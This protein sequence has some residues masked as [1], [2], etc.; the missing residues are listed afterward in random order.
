MMVMVLS[1]IFVVAELGLL[2]CTILTLVCKFKNRKILKDVVAWS[3][4]CLTY[5]AIAYKYSERI[6]ETEAVV[7]DRNRDS[8][9][10]EFWGGIKTYNY[11][12]ELDFNSKHECIMVSKSI[13]DEVKVGDTVNV[14][15]KTTIFNWITDAEIIGMPVDRACEQVSKN[16]SENG[17]S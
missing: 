3:L 15:I 11:Y 14:K 8:K 5:T 7:T 2:I 10:S 6:V 9:D 1:V 16:S 13:Y 17:R 4:I 12:L